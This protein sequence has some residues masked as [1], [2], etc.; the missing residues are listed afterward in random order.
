MSTL[1][2]IEAAAETLTP[3]QKRELFLFLAARLRSVSG[4]LPPPRD[5][6]REQIADDE[7]GMRRLR[8]ER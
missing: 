1:S 5:F 6:T 2:E 7:S 4:P 8:E 3:E